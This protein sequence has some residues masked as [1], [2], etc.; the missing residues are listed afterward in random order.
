M[1]ILGILG[2]FFVIPAP[3]AWVMGSKAKKE[4][5]ATGAHYSNEQLINIGRI[6]G[7]VFTM[8]LRR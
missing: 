7:I 1:L 4:I 6:L 8:P 2:I 5:A 3:I